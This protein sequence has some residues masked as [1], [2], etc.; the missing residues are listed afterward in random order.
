MGVGTGGEWEAL[1]SS[2]GGTPVLS[3]HRDLQYLLGFC[4]PLHAF[5]ILCGSFELKA[6][7]M[8]ISSQKIQLSQ[9]S[10]QLPERRGSF[11]LTGGWGINCLLSNPI[12]QNKT[13]RVPRNTGKLSR[14]GLLHVLALSSLCSFG[15]Y[16]LSCSAIRV[17]TTPFYQAHRNNPFKPYH[18]MQSLLIN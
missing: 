12:S 15:M 3:P 10:S 13:S 6:Y 1:D 7:R 16:H 8:E 14:H 2:S 17:N 9:V 11:T 5:F 4:F 18:F